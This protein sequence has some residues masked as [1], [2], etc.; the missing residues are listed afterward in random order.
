MICG[1]FLALLLRS[2]VALD[3]TQSRRALATKAAQFSA[4]FVTS[5]VA[6][7]FAQAPVGGFVA[8]PIEISTVKININTT[9]ASGFIDLPGMYPKVAS[10]IVEHVRYQGP[11]KNLDELYKMDEVMENDKIKAILV[12]NEAR[13]TI[14]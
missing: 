12:K 11:F 14:G 10:L 13:F 9:P 6:P 2:A 4:A 8:K 7:A 5:A 3:A 1:L